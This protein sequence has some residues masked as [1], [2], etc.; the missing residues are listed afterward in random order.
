MNTS[1]RL[2]IVRPKRLLGWCSLFLAGSQAGRCAPSGTEP[3]GL[4]A[5]FVLLA[6][7]FVLLL[8]VPAHWLDRWERLQRRL[9]GVLLFAGTYALVVT[10]LSFPELYTFQ[11]WGA[12]LLPGGLAP[13]NPANSVGLFTGFAAFTSQDYWMT[14][15]AV[16][17]PDTEVLVRGTRFIAFDEAKRQAEA[18][19]KKEAGGVQLPFIENPSRN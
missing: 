4:L 14:S 15:R 1:R 18:L 11:L 2:S 12:F 17:P 16:L 6:L 5:A 7:P 8:T 3:H 9:R 13:W 19:R 10:A